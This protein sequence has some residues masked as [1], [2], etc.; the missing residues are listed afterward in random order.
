MFALVVITFRGLQMNWNHQVLY[1]LSY[2]ARQTP[3][4]VIYLA[5]GL[6][7]DHLLSPE[8]TLH[9]YHSS[10]NFRKILYSH[11]PS[12]PLTPE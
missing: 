3:K 11:K 10:V 6:H 1:S 8:Q 7:S 4:A 12:A 2:T 5:H 9:S